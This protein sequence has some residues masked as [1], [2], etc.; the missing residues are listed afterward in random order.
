MRSRIF[1]VLSILA[2]A[3]C[4]GGGSE[5]GGG[6][7]PQPYVLQNSSQ[8]CAE[9]TPSSQVDQDNL[10]AQG[11]YPGTCSRSNYLGVC[12]QQD[13]GSGFFVSVVYYQDSNGLLTTD[14]VRQ[15]CEM[16]Q[17]R[18]IE[19]S[20][21]TSNDVTRTYIMQSNSLS[22]LE[23][24]GDTQASHNL[25]EGSGGIE[26]VCSREQAVGV[27]EKPD[28]GIGFRSKTVYYPGDTGLMTAEDF[29][30]G[31]ENIGGTFIYGSD[32]VEPTPDPNPEPTPDPTPDV[33]APVL[34]EVTGIGST[35]DLSPSY[36]FNSTES[37]QI[38]WMQG[39]CTS[40]TTAV[41]EGNNLIE[42]SALTSG[43]YF[44]CE[45]TVTDSADNQSGPLILSSFT[46]ITPDS[47]YDGFADFAEV[48]YGTDPLDSVSNPMAILG[49]AVNFSDDNDS[50]GFSDQLEAWYYTDPNHA[51]SYPVDLDGDDVPDGFDGSI[52]TD[53]PQLLGFDIVESSVNVVTG[54]EIV[55]FNLTVIDDI[56]GVASVSVY[57]KGPSGQTVYANASGASLNGLVHNLSLE[58]SEFGVHAEAALWS[59]EYISI[60]DLAGNHSFLNVYDLR[61]LGRQN[62]INVSNDNGDSTP[63]QL[64]AFTVVEDQVDI[65]MGTETVTFD[66][67]VSD[68]VSGVASLAIYLKSPN[69]QTVYANASGASLGGLEHT[70]SLESSAFGLSAE[71]GIW[72]IDY[73]SIYDLSGIHTMYRT[74]DIEELGGTASVT[75]NN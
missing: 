49:N 2:L 64:T 43:D 45:F 36:E 19:G 42:L 44:N 72:S 21:D 59:I 67:T 11:W 66:F 13:A 51:D 30:D 73:I 58:S 5:E 63:P 15:S 16:A 69:G 14:M 3:A 74:S 22:C 7:Y 62:T 1:L 40:E 12:E 27:C 57:L 48:E 47:D 71:A 31:C 8:L 9:F 34:S 70:L 52:D 20:T 35:V 25:I 54:T 68:D 32:G 53:A 56:S 17:G 28:N 18:F 39:S 65:V 4:G 33:T 37:G 26:G 55:T 29:V 75:I 24:I 46:I 50:D 60:Y 10:Q 41:V 23:Y 6:F 38:T 61:N